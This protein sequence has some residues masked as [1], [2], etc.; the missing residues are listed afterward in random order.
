MAPEGALPAARRHGLPKDAKQATKWY[1]KMQACKVETAADE[2]LKE[3][4]TVMKSA[5]T[6]SRLRAKMKS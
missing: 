1:R 4:F 3:S 2:S 5:K 6:A